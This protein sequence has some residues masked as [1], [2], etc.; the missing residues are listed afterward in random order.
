M[1][2]LVRELLDLSR[3]EAGAE[4]LRPEDVDLEELVRRVFARLERPLAEKGCRLSLD[5]AAV[6]VRGDCEKLERAVANYASNAL[7]HCSPGGEVR[8]KLT[9]PGGWARI[10]VENDGENIPAA[11][12]PRLFETFYRG[13]SARSRDSGGAGLGL[14]IVRGMANLHGGRCGAENLPGGVRFWME[15][16]AAY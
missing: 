10:A 3:L 15:G 5:L 8:V 9:G 2:A 7:R 11:E 4:T 12:L 1:D 6:R 16:P 14:A 13:D